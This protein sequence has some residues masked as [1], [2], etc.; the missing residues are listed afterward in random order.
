MLLWQCFEL[1]D[2]CGSNISTNQKP[3]LHT[4]RT[5]SFFF[6][7][8]SSHL[9]LTSWIKSAIQMQ[10][11]EPFNRHHRS[12]PFVQSDQA[13]TKCDIIVNN[14]ISFAYQ[15]AHVEIM[16]FSWSET[17]FAIILSY[18]IRANGWSTFWIKS[19]DN[20]YK[21]TIAI[22][23]LWDTICTR[24]SYCHSIHILFHKKNKP[25]KTLT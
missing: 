12:L 18:I 23:I 20:F 8:A 13:N 9:S 7:F 15:R 24:S 21:S 14:F 17:E 5:D 22:S 16:L 3:H 19:R 2:W 6:G 25:K 10:M 11:S 4:V 1:F